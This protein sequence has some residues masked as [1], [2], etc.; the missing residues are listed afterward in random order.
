MPLFNEDG[1]SFIPDGQLRGNFTMKAA[2]FLLDVCSSGPATNVQVRACIHRS[3]ASPSMGSM[4][5]AV[6]APQ[7]P[8]HL[9][10]PPRPPPQHLQAC[11]PAY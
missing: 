1:D 4:G 3:V 9:F 11:L 6:G 5:V 8:A 10:P 2:V 7:L